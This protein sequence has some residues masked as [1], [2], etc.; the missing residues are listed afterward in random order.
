MVEIRAL[1]IIFITQGLFEVHYFLG[2]CIGNMAA[3]YVI[4]F[5]RFFLSQWCTKQSEL[6]NEKKR[7]VEQ[8]QRIKIGACRNI[9]IPRKTIM[10]IDASSLA[11]DDVVAG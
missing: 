10:Y 11:D 5:P 4:G 2:G 7:G 1:L 8:H 3:L 9:I 6:I